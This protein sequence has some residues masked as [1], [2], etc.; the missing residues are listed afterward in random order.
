MYR[1]SLDDGT[2]TIAYVWADNENYWPA[3]QKEPE[4][5]S[6]GS[7]IDLFE[8]AHR[9]LRA[10]Q[11]RTPRIHKIDRSQ[12]EDPADIAVVEDVPGDTLEALLQENPQAADPALL[13]QVSGPRN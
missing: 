7:G 3:E 10:L 2:T 11:I 8:A 1:L 13:N 6:P 5:F 9:R 12:C 4:P